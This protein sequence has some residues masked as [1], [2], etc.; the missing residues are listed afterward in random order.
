MRKNSEFLLIRPRGALRVQQPSVHKIT[1]VLG[2]RTKAAR[3]QPLP[4][5]AVGNLLETV[6]GSFPTRVE[7][8]ACGIEANHKA[9]VL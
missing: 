9:G 2:E 3:R 5:L 4:V 8:V 1:L 7:E 6:D